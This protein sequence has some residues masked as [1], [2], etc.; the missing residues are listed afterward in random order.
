MLY[1]IHA[2]ILCVC[3]SVSVKDLLVSRISS[4]MSFILIRE[5][6]ASSGTVCN[7]VLPM[8]AL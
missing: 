1:I 5:L 8:S 4:S 6:E 7:P 2:F 3:Q